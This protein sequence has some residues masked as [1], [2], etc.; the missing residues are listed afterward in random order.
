MPCTAVQNAEC[1]VTNLNAFRRA[2]LNSAA[3]LLSTFGFLPAVIGGVILAGILAATMSTA[4]SQLLAAASSVSQDIARDTLGIKLSDRTAMILARCT[5]IVIALIG[6]IWA[7]N[8]G[9]V[10]I[11]G[12]AV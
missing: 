7:R 10:F 5:V 2:D 6:V 12:L 4:D 3:E 8:E 1:V 11:S 9:S